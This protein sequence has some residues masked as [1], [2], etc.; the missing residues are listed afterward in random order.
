MTEG[1]FFDGNGDAIELWLSNIYNYYLDTGIKVRNHE[2]VYIDRYT[3]LAIHHGIDISSTGPEP[4]THLTNSYIG[5]ERTGAIIDMMSYAMATGNTFNS[6]APVPNANYRGLVLDRSQLPSNEQTNFS[7]YS[8][9]KFI[10]TAYSSRSA[11]TEVAIDVISANTTDIVDND[12]YDMDIGVRVADNPLSVLNRVKNRYRLCTTNEVIPA[13]KREAIGG[14]VRMVVHNAN[15][16]VPV[17]TYVKLNFSTIYED[18]GGN[19]FNPT[20]FTYR[21]P[22]GQYQFNISA[23]FIQ[24]IVATDVCIVELARTMSR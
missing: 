22:T 17:N 5:S 16:A 6:T 23:R 20:D 4:T 9:N 14:D 1:M 18:K 8:N 11:Y 3:S 15:I 24:D 2:G 13:P 12:I 7:R 19:Y 10:G 21:P